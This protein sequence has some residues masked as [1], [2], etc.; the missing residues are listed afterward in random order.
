MIFLGWALICYGQYSYKKRKFGDGRV[1]E[2]TMGRHTE[3]IATHKPR[4]ARGYQKL[5]ERCGGFPGGSM[6]KNLPTNAEGRS[7][8]PGLGGSHML[9]SN[10][11]RE[12]QPLSL[13]SRAWELQLP[14]PARP[15]PVLCIR[16]CHRNEEPVP[17]S[18]GAVPACRSSRKSPR[19]SGGPAEPGRNGY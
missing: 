8:V 1:R 4:D 10:G 16:R 19:S 11:A 6:A 15:K 14:K 2:K 7:S 3:K 17:R 18:W 9:R 5:K 12:P 13:C